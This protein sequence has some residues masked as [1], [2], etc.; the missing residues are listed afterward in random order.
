MR[1][2]SWLVAGMIPGVDRQPLKKLDPDPGV[3]LRLLERWRAEA[4]TAGRTIGR[5]TLAYEAGL[6]GFRPYWAAR[7]RD[8]ACAAW[9]SARTRGVVRA[10]P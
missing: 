3:L 1:E 5:V 8:D 7:A 9:S 6:D 2:A 10:E 4:V